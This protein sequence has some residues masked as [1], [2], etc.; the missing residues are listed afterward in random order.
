MGRSKARRWADEDSDTERSP[1]NSPTSYLDAICQG[2][3]LWMSSLL[4][5]VEPCCIVE[6]SRGSIA[7]GRGK[8]PLAEGAWP[9]TV[10]EGA[11]NSATGAGV[12]HGW[13]NRRSRRPWMRPHLVHG[14]PAR[15]VEG[16]VP[17]GNASGVADGAPLASA[18]PLRTPMAG[19]RSCHRGR[20]VVLVGHAPLVLHRLVSGPLPAIRRI[21]MGSASTVSPPRTG[22]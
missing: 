5:R 6:G 19:V 13:R 14:L 9:A 4:E 11:R 12:V 18:S 8:H 16:R 20:L 7:A 10:A 2:S 1:V 21:Y 15:P 22:W 3:Q 17:P